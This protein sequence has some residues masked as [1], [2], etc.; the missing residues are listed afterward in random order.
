MYTFVRIQNLTDKQLY[1]NISSYTGSRRHFVH[2]NND[3]ESK[4]QRLYAQ[5]F[6]FIQ[7]LKIH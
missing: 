2:H 7:V 6:V 1:G 4:I 5:T 3:I